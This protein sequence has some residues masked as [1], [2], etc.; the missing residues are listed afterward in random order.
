MESCHMCHTTNDKRACIIRQRRTGG[1]IRQFVIF[2]LVGLSGLGV[3]LAIINVVM[4]WKG[5]F[6]LA[7]FLAFFIAVT[8]NFFLNRRF[9]FKS[10]VRRGWI[11]QWAM[12]VV[13]CMLGT[14][15]NWAVSFS[16]YY[17]IELF[18]KH[19]NLAVICGVTVGYLCNFTCAKF[20]VFKPRNVVGG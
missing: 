7:N 14:I 2:G 3:A 9:T 6:L 5:N 18:Y 4:A 1:T 20:A 19:H 10:H 15:C 8:W 16:L 12:F 11:R 13:S 17:G